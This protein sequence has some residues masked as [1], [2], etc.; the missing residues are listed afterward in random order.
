MRG[1]EPLLAMRLR[2]RRPRFARFEVDPKPCEWADWADWPQWSD[3]PI[4]EVEPRDVIR[5]LDLR[6]VV[7][8]PTFAAGAD[9]QRLRAV[10]QALLDAGSPR[11]IA[12][13]DA[14]YEGTVAFDT[15]GGE[16]WPI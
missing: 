4:I 7:G 10:V 1:H 3:V 11:V 2:G 5:R 6:C 8:M 12:V 9:A 14:G 16:P 13:L 15:A